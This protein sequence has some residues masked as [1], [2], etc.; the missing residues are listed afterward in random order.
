[1][2]TRLIGEDIDIRL[3]LD[4]DLPSILADPSQLEQILIN[5]IVNAR[6]A[7]YE[8]TPEPD[9]KIIS[10]ETS[11]TFL[12][13]KFAAKHLGFSLWLILERTAR[14]GPGKTSSRQ[15]RR[16]LKDNV[17]RAPLRLELAL[18]STIL[19]GDWRAT[20]RQVCQSSDGSRDANSSDLPTTS[21]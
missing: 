1:M 10:I 12:D 19:S 6:D 17:G 5:L 3:N 8:L 15:G 20:N 18:R 2:F 13:E 9:E 7:I 21:L 11:V 16:R 4:K 14:R